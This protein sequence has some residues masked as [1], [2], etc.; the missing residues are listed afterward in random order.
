MIFLK[1]IGILVLIIFLIGLIPVGADVRYVQ[2]ELS[3]SAKICGFLMKLYPKEGKK[4]KP[5]KQKP[6]K[7]AQPKQDK[8]EK[9][10]SS[11]A[12]KKKKQVRRNVSNE[13]VI[14][15]LKKVFQGIGKF[16]GGFHCDKFMLHLTLGG[17]DPA[18]TAKLFAF[19]NA[20]LSALA[21]V[22]AE[23]SGCKDTDVWTDVDFLSEDTAID[24]EIAIVLRIGS[25]FAMLNTILFGVLWIIIKN[26]A[27][28]FWWKHFDRDEY[29]YQLSCESI[30]T[31]LLKKVTAKK[32]AAAGEESTS[33]APP[34][35][36]SPNIE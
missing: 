24:F 3:V 11:K 25:L 8:K 21:P 7:A 14:A 6:P 26:K 5:K 28:W 4:K 2:K 34:A 18:D 32:S 19:I 16:L 9:K 30:V 35:D 33:P 10:P 27:K 29:E 15:L 1:I 31:K 17:D 13:E 23:R 22:C 20:S 36:A 12:A